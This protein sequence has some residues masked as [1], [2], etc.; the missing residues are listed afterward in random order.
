MLC[1]SSS[2]SRVLSRGRAAGPGAFSPNSPRPCPIFW[3]P[4]PDCAHPGPGRAEGTAGTRTNFLP[5]PKA[6]PKAPGQRQD[7]GPGEFQPPPLPPP[8]NPLCRVLGSSL[9]APPHTH[10]PQGPSGR[11]QLC[12]LGGAPWAA[13][14]F[15]G[16]KEGNYG[17]FYNISSAIGAEGDN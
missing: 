9:C 12:S 13:P 16:E 11:L 17:T 15:L 8:Q 10:T 4:Q 5:L 1:V 2:W 6:P 3:W 7:P 14:S